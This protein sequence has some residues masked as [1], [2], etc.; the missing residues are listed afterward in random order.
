MHLYAQCIQRDAKPRGESSAAVDFLGFVIPMVLGDNLTI[1]VAEICQ[2]LLQAVLIVCRF[3]L[4]SYCRQ[5]NSRF[6]S[7]FALPIMPLEGL[8]MNQLGDTVD[9]ASKVIDILTLVDSPRDAIYRFVGIDIR[10]FRSAPLKVLQQ[11]KPEVLIL[12]SRLVA[13]SV[14][15]G[16]K[17]V[18]RGLS[19]NP[20][21]F[22]SKFGETHV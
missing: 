8:C 20:F 6:F 21:G 18:K 2:T 9:V 13:I 7:E 19:E 15:R 12:L 5:F 4:S 3:N 16:K 14:E 17:A 22:G 11:L 10:C 1:F